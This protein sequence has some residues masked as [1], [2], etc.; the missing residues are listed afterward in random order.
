MKQAL[1]WGALAL[2]CYAYAGFPLLVILRGM[3]RRRPVQRAEIT[4]TMSMV[5]IAY[6]EE[7]SIGAKLD[8][9]LSLDYPKGL[10]EVIVASDGSDDRTNEI[11][12]SYADRGVKF[13][14]LPRQGK[15]PALNAAVA[16]ATGEILAFSDANSMF[17]TESLR[18]LARPFADPSVGGVCGDQS[19]LAGTKAEGASQGERAYWNYDRI[20]KEMES[21]A[22]NVISGT[23]AIYAIRHSLFSPIPSGVTDDFVNTTRVV[24]QGKRLIFEPNAVAYEPVAASS[25]AEYKRKVRVITRGFRGILAVRPLL[26]PFRFGFYSL[27]MLSHKVLRRL[28]ALP[29]IAMLCIS[30][31]LW[32][33]GLFYQLALALQVVFYGCAAMGQ[34]LRKTRLGSMKVFTIPFYFSLV[35]V[36]ALNAAINILRGRRI[37]IWQPQRE[38][39]AEGTLSKVA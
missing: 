16:Q 15:I 11:V 39:K 18:V 23:G 33:E 21:R 32:N 8:N 3:L 28:V 12:A 22:G 27:Q 26:N 38:A 13:L 30:P 10:V 5:I 35:N 4:P 36:A 14:P 2:V 25:D 7:D 24:L 29:L 9:V 31:F 34:L 17:S 37:D 20:L 19:Y 1:F 6:N